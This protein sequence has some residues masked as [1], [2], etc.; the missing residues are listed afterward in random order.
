MASKLPTP[1]SRLRPPTRLQ[2]PA[3]GVSGPKRRASDEGDSNPS[4]SKRTRSSLK[5]LGSSLSQGSENSKVSIMGPPTTVLRRPAVPAA[6]N[7]MRRSVSMASLAVGSNTRNPPGAGF[8]STLS[9][10]NSKLSGSNISLTGRPSSTTT[11]APVA[12]STRRPGTNITSRVNNAA[13]PPAA[14]K[15]PATETAQ[16][17]AGRSK[18]PA[19]DTK[20]RLQD[21]EETV[22]L[23][24]AERQDN[25]DK[26]AKFESKLSELHHEKQSLNSH[27]TVTSSASLE[28]QAQ[29]D[30]LQAQLLELEQSGE[31]K[32]RSLERS[33]RRLEEDLA[34]RERDNKNLSAD[35]DIKIDEINALK[36]TLS[37]CTS[38]QALVT[39]QLAA[40]TAQVAERGAEVVSLRA[41][42]SDAQSE[43]SALRRDL[44]QGEAFRK[45]LHNQVQELKVRADSSSMSGLRSHASGAVEF[46]YDRV[47]GPK[48]TQADVF[49]EVSQLVQSTLDGYNVCVFAYGQTGSGKTYTMEGGSGSDAGIIPR[50][51]DH[52]FTEMTR[53]AEQGWE[54]K[55]EV[56]ILEIYNEALRDL[57][58]SPADVKNLSYEIKLT[59]ARSA[60]TH[61]TNLRLVSVSSPEEIYELLQLAQS[62]RAV[63]ATNMN[64]RSSRSHSVFR[65][66][67]SGTQASS[68]TTVQGSLSLVDLAGSERLKESGS[69]GAR[70][71]E[72]QNINRSLSNLGNVIMAIAQK[73]S[74]VPYRNSKLTHLLQASLGG[75]SKT[76]MLVN[77][78]PLDACINETLNS[79]RFAAKV[80]ACHIGTA[81][82]MAKKV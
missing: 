15:A 40:A 64:A 81:S 50:T 72:T 77:V 38:A 78:S 12:A 74:H 5:D 23:L 70:L 45:K 41:A 36:R 46:A 19:W 13:R 44:L 71:T 52:I 4:P 10:S 37:E 49:E 20:G 65:L 66:A 31:A 68:A 69:Q 47:F 56:S 35:L 7:K 51:V 55:M 26:L 43:I 34:A 39:A 80:N 42:L 9:R 60:H 54:Y 21:M 58:A 3:V 63:A 57:L 79:L 33:I 17:P 18:R 11:R 2:L 53:L 27:L 24:T 16:L 14:S 75:N 28:K 6:R 1:S 61:V 59:D 62:H 73:Q 22:R 8:G 76:L 29:L 32:C 82:K 48:H 25:Q 30:K 67:L